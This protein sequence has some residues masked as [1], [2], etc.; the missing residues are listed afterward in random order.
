MGFGAACTTKRSFVVARVYWSRS[1]ADTTD[2]YAFISGTRATAWPSDITT[3]YWSQLATN[4]ADLWIHLAMTGVTERP[5]LVV[6][7][8]NSPSSAT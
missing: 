4:T 6:A 5:V 1:A 7:C 2:V 3:T 8:D